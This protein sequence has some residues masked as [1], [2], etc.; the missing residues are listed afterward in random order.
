M[1]TPLT[2]FVGSF[3]PNN[4]AA[5]IANMHTLFNIVTTLLLLPFGSYLATFA[6][7]ILPIKEEEE[8]EDL[9]ESPLPT[10]SYQIGT[11]AILVEQ[12]E[13]EINNIQ[14]M[15]F[16]NINESLSQL[17]EFDKQREKKLLKREEK[18]DEFN[19]KLSEYITEALG[20]EQNS[21]NSFKMSVYYHL[22]IDIERISNYAVRI[23]KYKE[24]V[25]LNSEEKDRIGQLQNLI[26]MASKDLKDLKKE[27]AQY[28]RIKAFCKETKKRQ[29]MRMKEK[30]ISFELTL[31][32]SQLV[33]DVERINEHMFAIARD[34]DMITVHEA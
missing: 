19:L 6:E 14:R 27:E 29:I 15:A 12:I 23:Q 24:K 3:T 10:L 34:Y 2:S 22:L 11:S 21:E 8:P 33:N 18:V 5:Q 16:K 9:L 7:K 30:S 1:L 32:F 20:I 25:D 26:F 28:A 13:H 31:F 4:A 17:V